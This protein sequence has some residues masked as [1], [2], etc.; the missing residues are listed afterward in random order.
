MTDLDATK[1]ERIQQILD[2]TPDTERCISSSNGEACAGCLAI[3]I[4]RILDG[5]CYPPLEDDADEPR[6]HVL[7]SA[8]ITIT[9]TLDQDGGDTIH[10]V[11]TGEA[12]DHLVTA[13]GMLE[14]AK[15]D[16]ERAAMEGGGE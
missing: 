3:R 16:I 14:L 13:Y 10:T 9:R 6:F 12:T 4:R 1:L 11:T 7:V 5:T 2:E 15:V 8:S